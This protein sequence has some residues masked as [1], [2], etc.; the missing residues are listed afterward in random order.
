MFLNHY[1]WQVL[2][3]ELEQPEQD[4]PAELLKLPPLLK[5]A[6]DISFLT[7]SFRHL[8]HSTAAVE[9]NTSSSKSCPHR[10][11]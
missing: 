1:Q 5:L 9:E 10:S 8:G 4:G 11:Q 3:L 6:A 7:W 2:Q